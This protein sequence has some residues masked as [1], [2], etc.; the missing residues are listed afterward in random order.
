MDKKGFTL[1]ELLV[2]I[3]IAIVFLLGLSGLISSIN[4][5]KQKG[6]IIGEVENQGLE[7]MRV[8]TQN[9]RNADTINSPAAGSNATTL[10]LNLPSPYANPMV[11]SLSG[12]A[13]QLT[14]GASSAVA[15]HNS[16]VVISDL[17]FSNLSRFGTP[18]AIKIQF[19]LSS[20]SPVGEKMASNLY[21]K[22]F[23]GSASLR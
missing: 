3:A 22:I 5:A 20:N 16:K 1:I 8:I 15:L 17:T 10:S 9:I 23:Y 7:I 13:L 19:K 18:G 4:Q 6:I 2:Y 12:Q 21:E 11:F 14:E